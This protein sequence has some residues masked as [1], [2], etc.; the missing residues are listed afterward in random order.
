MSIDL[1]ELE[2]LLADK[3]VYN[4]WQYVTSLCEN[5]E[6][7]NMSYD[8]IMKVFEHRKDIC[9]E[10]GNEIVPNLRRDLKIQLKC[11]I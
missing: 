5:I 9:K 6:Y 11:P 7:M 4:A 10:I 3:K 1:A 2:K 8:L